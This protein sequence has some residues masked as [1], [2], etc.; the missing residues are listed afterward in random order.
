[1]K[2]LNVALIGYQFMGRTHSNAW[3]QVGR[4]FDLPCEP[5][6]KVVCGRSESELERAASKLGFEQFSTSW[7]EVVA[8]KDIDVIDICTPGDSHLPIALAAAEAKKVVF[9]EKPL[10]NTLAEAE[11]MLHAVRRAGVL[12]MLCHNYRR[13]P[14]VA[15]AKQLID[16]GWIG[17]IQ[18]FRGVYLQDW[19]V[20]PA[21]PRVWRLEK[22]KA[23]SGALGDIG[24]HSLD[25]ARYLVG[26]IAEVT[27][28]M[29]TFVKERPLPGS[30]STAPVD[31]DDA[32]LALL[33]FENG[34]LGSVEA[35]R[36]AP[37]RK[38]HN[39]FEINGKKGSIA[40]DL[41]HM[42]ELELYEEEGPNSGFRTVQVTDATHPYLSAW[43]PPGHIIGY[44]HSFTHTV[45]DLIQA[46]AEQKLPTPNFEDG[47]RNQKVL[48]AIERSSASGH[49]EQSSYT[50]DHLC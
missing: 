1:M 30:S 9:C 44:E 6:L 48:D 11:R 14:A 29:K 24:S 41:E 34:A 28:T 43:W 26:E 4:F 15:L 19:I 27:G 2:K 46:I 45:R 22:A 16:E 37:G 49:W 17:T 33:K 12:H 36:F 18:H 20:D 21:F 10:A 25:L 42:N 5:V 35:S 8:R 39:R 7:Q 31:V 13:V 40:W 38:N 3:R 50:D 47:V 32:A 23:G